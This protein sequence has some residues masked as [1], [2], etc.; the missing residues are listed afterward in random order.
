LIFPTRDDIVRL[1]RS[2]ISRT[3]GLFVEPDNLLNVSSLEW[4]LEAIQGPLF[5]F[6]RYPTFV[7]KAAILAWTIIRGHV[8]WDGNKRTGMATLEVFIE[9]NR[10]RLIAS[11][12]EMTKVAL[13]IADAKSNREYE[14][15]DFVEWVKTRLVEAEE[16]SQSSSY[17]VKPKDT[18]I[19]DG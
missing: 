8:F 2:L 11:N 14:F 15:R 7:E 19:N 3:K 4:V 5:G 13:R 17:E 6:E 12:D 1:N 10:Y 18:S 16:N 9:S